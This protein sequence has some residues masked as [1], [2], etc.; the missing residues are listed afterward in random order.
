MSEV[1]TAREGG[2]FTITLNRPDVF[3]AFNRDLHAAFR[4]ALEEAADPRSAPLSSPA[5]G[6][7]FCAGQDLREFSELQG[8]IGEALEATYHPTIR[9]VR[10]LEKPVLAAVNGPAAGRGSL[11]RG[12]LRRPRRIDRRDLRPGLRRHR[13]RPGLGWELVPVPAARIRAGLR[14]D[15]LEPAPRRGGGAR[16]GPRLEGDSRRRVRGAGGR[17]R[18]DLGGNADA[19]RGPDETAVRG[20]T[21]GIARGAARTRGGAAAGGDLDRPT[22]PKE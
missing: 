7:G 14:M 2:V 15:E 18:R 17:D 3:N 6:G 10:G 22:S 9:L 12:R 19:R 8:S 1:L 11:A 4:G 16:V 20:R 21:H 5:R 13:P